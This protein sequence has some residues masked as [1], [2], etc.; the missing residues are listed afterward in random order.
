MAAGTTKVRG[1]GIKA[2]PS[3]NKKAT[4][5]LWNAKQNIILLL[6]FLFCSLTASFDYSVPGP[7]GL[8][9]H[10]YSGR[11]EVLCWMKIPNLE[12][13]KDKGEGELE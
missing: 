12:G 7:S 9:I 6:Q 5:L 13:T 10:R 1:Y 11:K 4:W 8:H 2:L 3:E